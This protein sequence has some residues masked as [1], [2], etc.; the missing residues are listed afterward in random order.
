MK[1]LFSNIILDALHRC[2]VQSVVLNSFTF[3]YYKF[4]WNLYNL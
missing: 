3:N 1:K 2:I 4:P